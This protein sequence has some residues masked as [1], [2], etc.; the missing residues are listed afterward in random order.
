MAAF[1]FGDTASPLFGIWTRAAPGVRRKHGVLICPPIAQEHVRSHWALRQVAVALCR[2][3]F[4]VLRFDW[5]GVGDSAGSLSEA[6]MERW[7]NDLA[8]AAQQLRSVAGVER[9]SIV[10]LRLGATIAALAA[11]EVKPTAMVLWDPV[12]DGQGYV[13]ELRRLT[14]QILED[15]NRYWTP[16]QKSVGASELVGFDFG[17]RLISEIQATVIAEL[18]ATALC[19]L[20]STSDAGLTNLTDGLGRSH[21][22]AEIKDADVRTSWTD[23]AGIER[24]LL[25]GDAVRI[26]AAFL[27]GRA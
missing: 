7:K 24:L 10:G 17:S 23:P 26:L 1:H 21:P 6:T 2:G 15:P 9:I 4:D 22:D 3:G 12:A 8:T 19:I 27:E 20:R 18:P 25:P 5:F 11:G 13:A 14:A 16:T